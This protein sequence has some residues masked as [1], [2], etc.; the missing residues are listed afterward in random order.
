MTRWLFEFLA[1]LLL[2]MLLE[3]HVR[4]CPD[5]YLTVHGSRRS[6][7]YDSDAK[8]PQDID[9]GLLWLLNFSWIYMYISY[10]MAHLY[11]HD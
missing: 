7:C 5:L 1:S 6:T 4:R 9:S 8:S 2:F 10:F 3:D 11:L